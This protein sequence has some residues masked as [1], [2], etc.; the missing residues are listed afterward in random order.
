MNGLITLD[1][2]NELYHY[3]TKR[4]SG[5]YPFGSGERPY[6]GDPQ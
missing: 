3:G 4:H 5:R 2:E 1:N 6:Q